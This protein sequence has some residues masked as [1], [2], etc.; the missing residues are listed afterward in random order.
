VTSYLG[1]SISDPS[2]TSLTVSGNSTL[3]GTVSGAGFTSSIQT[4]I[5]SNTPAIR[6]LPLTEV[7]ADNG[8]PLLTATA[9]GTLPGIARTA[10]TS[11]YLT[12]VAT[13]GAGSVTTKMLWEFV[14]PTTYV[15]GAAIPVY[16]NCVVPI[17]TDVTAA[18]TTMTVNAYAEGTTGL[19]TSLSV[20][21]AQ[22][23]PLTTSNTL[24][25]SV[26]GSGLVPG[27]RVALELTALVTTIT[28]GA[29]SVQVGSVGYSA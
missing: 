17:A 16:V 21:A 11:L 23:I 5:Q 4:V 28:G 22:Q 27:R 19:E 10:G 8:L 7:H 29:S 12:G 9:A 18:S 14:L 15:A 2:F 24:T 20:S 1:V 13:S 25:F 6:Y 26:T 3:T